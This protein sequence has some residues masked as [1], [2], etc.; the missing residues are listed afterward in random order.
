VI[1]CGNA[2]D[3]GEMTFKKVCHSNA[4]VDPFSPWFLFSAM[5]GS[6]SMMHALDIASNVLVNL[7]FSRGS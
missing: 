6:D 5:A 2:M 4:A 7:V 3:V 1:I